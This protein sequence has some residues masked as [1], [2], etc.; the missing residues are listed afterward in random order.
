L[1]APLHGRLRFQQHKDLPFFTNSRTS[2]FFTVG[3]FF[4]LLY[5]G[6]QTGGYKEQPRNSRL[7]RWAGGMNHEKDSIGNVQ[8]LTVHG[9]LPQSARGA[10]RGA[11]SG[12]GSCGEPGS[13]ARPRRRNRAVWIADHPHRWQRI[14]AGAPRSSRFLLKSLFDGG[15]VPPLSSGRDNS[16]AARQARSSGANA[17]G[18]HRQPSYTRDSGVLTIY[19]DRSGTVERGGTGC[20]GHAESC[21]C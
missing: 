13:I 7:K 21:G 3:L 1:C 2:P 5:N 9:G 10:D 15:R 12:G 14:P 17:G 20:G 18:F 11:E 8:R 6:G 19:L 4:K 16:H